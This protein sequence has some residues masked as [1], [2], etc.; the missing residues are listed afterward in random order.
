MPCPI[1]TTTAI[2]ATVT[3]SL[4]VSLIGKRIIKKHKSKG[5][6]EQKK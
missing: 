6:K 5:K 4:A 1:C 3:Q 2:A